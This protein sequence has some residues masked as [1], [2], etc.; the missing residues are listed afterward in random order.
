MRSWA[1][2][3]GAFDWSAGQQVYASA[4]SFR[5]T[6]HSCGQIHEGMPSFGADAPLA[7]YALPRWRRL[8][9][10]SLGSD[11]SVIDGRQYYI[12]G[13][14]EVPVE[15]S[16]EPLV[17]GV[18]VSLDKP[19]FEQ[20]VSVF[21]ASE[22][23]HLGP[24]PGRLETALPLYLDTLQ[25]EVLVRLRDNGLRPLVELEPGDH[26]LVVEQR[27]GINIDRAVELCEIMLHG[28]SPDR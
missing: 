18:W 16:P 25:L 26:P 23:S 12:R 11:D 9:K 27:Q 22:R 2:V 4:V 10:A 17:W 13:C 24:Y 1:L 28:P 7:Y 21:D 20:W 6:C 15:S 19:D 8:A 14:L 3:I 5:F